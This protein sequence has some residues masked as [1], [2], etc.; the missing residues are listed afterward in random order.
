MTD[1]HHPGATDCS[2]LTGLLRVDGTTKVWGKTFQ[3]LSTRY[4]GTRVPPA[5]TGPRPALDWDACI[6]SS[7]STRSFR[8]QYY[9]AFLADKPC[10]K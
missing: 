8:D 9:K 2:E 6:T 4:S 10:W 7:A 3:Q 5:T 1:K